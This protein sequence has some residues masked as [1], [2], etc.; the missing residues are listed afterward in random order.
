MLASRKP[1][2]VL[3]SILMLLVFAAP[4]FAEPQ[5]LWKVGTLAP[6]GVGWAK[7]VE[8]ILLPYIAQKTNKQLGIKVFWGGVMGDDSDYIKKM[9]I[10]QLQAG[11]LTA[12]GAILISK[13]W[14][15][16][17]IPFLF[18]SYAEVD[19]VRPKMFKT[20]EAMMAKEG[21]KLLVWI[22]QDFDKLYS[23]KKP[24]ASLA[25]FRGGRIVTWYGPLEKEVLTRLGASPIP[26]AV[27]EISAS[28]RS[29]IADATIAPAIWMVGS[30]M[31]SVAK[32]VNPMNI[33]YAPALIVVTNKAWAEIPEFMRKGLES[34]R[35]KL[36]RDFV[37]D[38]RKD[39]DRSLDA[40]LKYGMR[41]ATPSPKELEEIRKVLAPVGQEMVGKLYPKSLLDEL[42]A[43]IAAARK[44]G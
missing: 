21:F 1:V 41:K 38:T 43:H 33:R 3:I 8:H 5:H 13:E 36:T 35:E 18:N 12:M 15:V 26:I 30:Q 22:D 9:R 32:Y 10:G 40:M 39:N 11:G 20:F 37:T 23:I 27:P 7:Q 28:L 14:A 2:V 16:V 34:E 29:G 17:E 6:K 42:L 31:H 4:C 44:K 19:Y 24:L 25:E